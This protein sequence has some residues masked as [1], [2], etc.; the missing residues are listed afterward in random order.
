M[1][2]SGAYGFG[3]PQN[4]EASPPLAPT[5]SREFSLLNILM[6]RNCHVHH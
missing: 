5:K 6:F 2:V 1:E 3:P 4:S